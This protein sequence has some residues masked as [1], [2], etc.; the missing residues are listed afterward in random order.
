MA[1]RVVATRWATRWMLSNEI[2]GRELS[3]DVKARDLPATLHR[4]VPLK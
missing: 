3:F 2:G 1:A 4:V